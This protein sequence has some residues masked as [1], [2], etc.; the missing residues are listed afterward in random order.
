MESDALYIVKRVREK[1][2][3]QHPYK[4]VFGILTPCRNI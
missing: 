4:H 1:L 3:K 2:L